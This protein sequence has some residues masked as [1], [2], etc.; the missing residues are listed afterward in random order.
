V[1]SIEPLFTVG[2]GAADEGVRGF[3]V[4]HSVFHGVATGG[5]R[6]GEDVSLEEVEHLARVM[7][8]KFCFWDRPSGGAKAGVVL[9]AGTAPEQR[10]RLFRAVGQHLA[11]LL[12]AGLYQPWPDLNCG[13]ED[14]Q[15]ILAGAGLAARQAPDSSYYTALTAFGALAA[16]ARFLGLRPGSC[17]ISIEGMGRVGTH[18]AR[19]VAE[20]GGRL[21]AVSTIEGTV[22][23]PEGL[24][25]AAL[26]AAREKHGDSFATQPGDWERVPRGDLFSV[27]TDILVPCARVGSIDAEVAKMLDVKALV[28]A[29][30]AP[31]TE[32]AEAELA[33]KGA[34]VLPD[35]ICNSGGVMGTRLAQLGVSP[36]R[37]RELLADELGSMVANALACSKKRGVSPA[38]LAREVAEKRHSQRLS[39]MHA[40]SGLRAAVTR[41]LARRVPRAWRRNAACNE[42][43]EITRTSFDEAG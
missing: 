21:A 5:V 42:F 12:G 34:I 39:Q 40:P 27:P 28:P 36:E 32:E 22:A 23:N 8:Y 7:T 4:V 24:D 14:V 2:F 35:F 43:L 20:W 3:L 41:R 38:D 15:A 18:L 26:L 6:A 37:T 11:P 33:R 1:I 13:P 9:P 16:T 17:R 31:C 30:N 10:V 19:Q 25:P 29:A